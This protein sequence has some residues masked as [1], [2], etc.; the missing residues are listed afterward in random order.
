[1]NIG[2]P[3]ALP[4][5]WQ[6]FVFK[7]QGAYVGDTTIT[8]YFAGN[9]NDNQLADEGI[10]VFRDLPASITFTR[11]IDLRV[12]NGKSYYYRALI[13]DLTLLQNSTTLD[14]NASPV[15][16]MRISVADG[17][18]YVARAV[19]KAIDAWKDASGNKPTLEKDVRVFKAHAR[20]KE[21]QLFVVVS[22][23][24]GQNVER[25]LDSELG[26]DNGVKIKGETDLDTIQIEWVSIGDP[27]R[28]DKLT[29]V[30]RVMRQVMRHFIIR[31]G[32]GKVR[33]VR[34][35]MS[36]DGEGQYQG[37]TAHI[38]RMTAAVQIENR[39]ELANLGTGTLAAINT[40]YQGVV[41]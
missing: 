20:R 7:K 28:R 9:L 3:S 38:G 6:L 39:L 8:D 40:T 29:N 24:A 19:E 30:F 26:E 37:E 13:R 27:E 12:E 33:D 34:F 14:V 41:L 2:Y 17:K 1:M 32:N 10:F 31:A 15:A 5:S 36:G 25:Y 4:N 23:V 11:L 18:D 35:T 22:R 21:E 16:N